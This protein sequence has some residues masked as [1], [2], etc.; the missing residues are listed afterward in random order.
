MID[1]CSSRLTLRERE[2]PANT[3]FPNNYTQWVQRD[4][5]GAQRTKA[6]PGGRPRNTLVDFERRASVGNYGDRFEANEG[7]TAESS[8]G[9]GFHDDPV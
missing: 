7:D 3:E 1:C 9:I 4:H 8:A 2:L 5:G 6:A